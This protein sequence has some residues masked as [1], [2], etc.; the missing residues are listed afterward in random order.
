MKHLTFLFIISTL[1]FSCG[2]DDVFVNPPSQI[3][4]QTTTL[5]QDDFEQTPIVIIGNKKSNYIVSFERILEDGTLLDFEV[6]PDGGA[7]IMK[8]NED[9]TWNVLGKCVEGVRLGSQLKSPMNWTGYWFALSS[10]YPNAEIYG[11]PLTPEPF[12]PNSASTDWLVSTTDLYR[13]SPKDGIVAVDNPEFYTISDL[14]HPNSD[15]RNTDYLTDSTLVIG[16]VV[17][18]EI[19]AYP[20]S[21]LNWH[22][23]INDY[24]GG[25]AISIIYCPLTGTASA[26]NRTINGVETT[27]GVS[28]ILYNN[29]V[30]P[31][32]RATNSN[33]SQVKSQCI[34]GSNISIIPQHYPIVETR[35]DTWLSMYPT[36]L[37]LSDNTPQ[38]H[39]CS[40]FPYGSHQTNP[41]IPYPILFQDNRRFVKERVH[42]VV[43]NGKAKVYPFEAF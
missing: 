11:E 12:T 8:D 1:L 21:V 33:W 5:I 42:S 29:N 3:T 39:N 14:V 18:G 26:W 34:N 19:K 17:N 4:V 32:D 10:F 28:G 27:F 37:V 9:N 7:I 2:K 22:E 23:I 6:I 20:H 43:I 38:S 16:I 41:R 24:V 13:G 25:E 40:L 35:W 15:T 31:Y 30:I 36:S